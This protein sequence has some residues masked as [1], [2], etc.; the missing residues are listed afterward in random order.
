MNKYLIEL[1]AIEKQ[2]LSKIASSSQRMVDIVQDSIMFFDKEVVER[3]EVGE[4]RYEIDTLLEIWNCKL[5]FDIR[6]LKEFDSVLKRWHDEID[7]NNKQKET[8]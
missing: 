2:V 5:T 1:K 4:V 6:I 8:E 3:D 7:F